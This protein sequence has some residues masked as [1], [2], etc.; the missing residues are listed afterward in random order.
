VLHAG[1]VVTVGVFDGL[2]LG[3]A[4][5]LQRLR[6]AARGAPPAGRLP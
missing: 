5:I 6:D 4:A 1:S 3:H 2:H